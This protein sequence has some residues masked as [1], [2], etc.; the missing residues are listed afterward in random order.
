LFGATGERLTK[1]T[2]TEKGLLSRT[3]VSAWWRGS[4]QV[5][6]EATHAVICKGDSLS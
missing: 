6:T 3:P 1:R 2:T 4:S 5:F